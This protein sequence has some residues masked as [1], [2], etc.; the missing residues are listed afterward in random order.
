MV[1]G[2]DEMTAFCEARLAE[3]ECIAQG[4]ASGAIG[5]DFYSRSG[6][7]TDLYW[8]YIDPARVLREVAAKRAI[9]A[10]HAPVP[11]VTDAGIDGRVCRVCW[12]TGREPGGRYLEG[13][14]YPCR[15]VRHLLTEWDDHPGYQPSW[16]PDGNGAAHG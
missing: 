10:E 9:L 7:D 14:P 15:T 4:L 11:G 6:A 8:G 2:M 12:T 13:D 3:D 5:T 16:A 1:Y